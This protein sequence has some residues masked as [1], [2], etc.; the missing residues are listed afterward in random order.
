MQNKIVKS[1]IFAIVIGTCIILPIIPTAVSAGS[2]TINAI[3]WKYGELNGTASL[4]LVFENDQLNVGDQ[5]T[6]LST[7]NYTSSYFDG[8][9]LWD[10]VTMCQVDA[11]YNY[12]MSQSLSGNISLQYDYLADYVNIQSGT[13]INYTWYGIK[14]TYMNYIY[15]I[16]D[17]SYMSYT[18]VSA[19]IVYYQTTYQKN[20]STSEILGITYN[21]WSDVYTYELFWNGTQD[22]ELVQYLYLDAIYAV[23]AQLSNLYFTDTT[24]NPIVW[25]NLLC[26][27]YIFADLNDNG[28]FDVGCASTKGAGLPSMM[29]SD[30]FRGMLMPYALKANITIGLINKTLGGPVF[31]YPMNYTQT[32]PEEV[33]IDALIDNCYLQWY[34]PVNTTDGVEFKWGQLLLDYP[35]L[36]MLP[37]TAPFIHSQGLETDYV[38]ANTLTIDPAGKVSL[39]TANMFGKIENATVKDLMENYSLAIPYYS[40]FLAPGQINDNVTRGAPIQADDFAF[41]LGDTLL[42]EIDLNNPLKVNYTLK[43]Y[44]SVGIDT[45][46][47]SKGSSVAKLITDV[48]ETGISSLMSINNPF[49]IMLYGSN[50]PYNLPTNYQRTVCYELINYP[51]W[52]GHQIVHDPI[53]IAYFGSGGGIP[54]FNVFFVLLAIPILIIVFLKMQLRSKNPF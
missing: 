53:F 13:T 19:D 17:I 41:K 22:P 44:P 31:G 6:V 12:T 10:T 3:E 11:I 27:S 16:T 46:L 48:G 32:I 39:E 9:Y 28:I 21:T 23:P 7:Y 4:V 36:A 43:D 29:Y 51:T 14:R 35:T 37:T 40:A 5:G 18:N 47:Q 20:A 38:Y 52:G 49:V 15:W 45:I 25:S 50:N 26:E 42:G 2:G 34:P 8:T 24:G 33:D 30:E 1:L 54:G